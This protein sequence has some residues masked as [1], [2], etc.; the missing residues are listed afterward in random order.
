[1]GCLSSKDRQ[2]LMSI[3]PRVQPT[4]LANSSQTPLTDSKRSNQIRENPSAPK[5]A[6]FFKSV[7]VIGVF[8]DRSI[9]IASDD[10]ED[11]VSGD[12]VSKRTVSTSG[13]RSQVY[14]SNNYALGKF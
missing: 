11:F 10:L 13:I 12:T 7:R 1:M 5:D 3:D 9:E 4:R 2:D 14:I 8:S 6:M